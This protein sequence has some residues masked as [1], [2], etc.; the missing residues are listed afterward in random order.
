MTLPPVIFIADAFTVPSAATVNV[1]FPLLITPPVM[2]IADAFTVP[3]SET[4]NVSFPL[5][6][7]TPRST[8]AVM[9][10]ATIA[11]SIVIAVP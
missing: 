1:P 2:D 9:K 3:S 7:S 4:W 5:T 11:P 8:P 6:I 10:S